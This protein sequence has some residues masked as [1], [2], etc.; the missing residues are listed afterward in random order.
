MMIIP[1]RKPLFSSPDPQWSAKRLAETGQLHILAEAPKMQESSLLQHVRSIPP[2]WQWSRA[3]V[4]V[5]CCL[6]ALRI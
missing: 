6:I 4:Q 2:L 1:I 5:A 3:N